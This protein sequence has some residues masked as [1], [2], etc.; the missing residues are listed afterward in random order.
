M[1][2]REDV[3]GE[4]RWR[5]ETGPAIEAEYGPGAHGATDA[6]VL[7]GIGRPGKPPYTRH[8]YPTGYRERPWAPSLYSGFGRPE[9]ANE[10]YRYLLA[11]GN[12]RANVA[13]DLPTQIG[14]DSDDPLAMGEVGRVGVALDSLADFE[15]MFDQVPLDRIPLSFNVNTTAPI[16]L[17]MLVA[18]ARKQGVDPAALSGTIAN[19]ILHEYLARGMWRNEPTGAL[20]LMADVVEYATEH[21]PR[22][23]PFNIRS[24]LLHESGAHPGQEIGF[25]FAIACRYVDE[26]IARGL[27]IDDF[28]PRMSFFFGT[29]THFLEEAAKFR[30]ARRLWCR[31]LAER[32]GASKPASLRLKLTSVAPCGSHFTAADPQLNLVRGTLGVLAGALGGV[33]AMLGTTIDEA[34]DIPTEETQRLALRTQ[35]IVTLESDVCATVDPLGGSYFI[36]ALTDTIEASA[37]EQMELLGGSEGVVEAITSGRAQGMLAERAYEL[38][39][40]LARGERL[41][42]SENIYVPDEIP[43][44]EL[45]QADAGLFEERKGTLAKLRSERDA[46]AV[47]AALESVRHALVEGTNVVQPMIVAAEAYAT[48]GEISRVIDDV[49]GVYQQPTGV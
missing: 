29:G 26:L 20:R 48:I 31:L 27:D 3:D 23:Y 40:E 47:D 2:V 35:Q 37:V 1:A 32:Y 30:A 17:A 39:N 25:T 44:L 11:Q 19:D 9:E 45:H 36:E 24:I 14:L 18:T 33:Q 12:G 6:S 16:V 46:A 8:I 34:Y 22:L 43:S 5:S 10:R 49:L 13:S 4:V 28:A 15:V 21:T 7:D 42:V 41:I 38:E